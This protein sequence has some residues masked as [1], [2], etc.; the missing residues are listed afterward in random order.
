MRRPTTATVII[1]LA[2][3]IAAQ[4]PVV[5]K[6][7]QL[8]VHTYVV[9]QPASKLV[10]DDAAML[11][12]AKAARR[13]LENDL[14]SYDIRDVTTRRDAFASLST[15]A[16]LEGRYDDALRLSDTV[17]ALQT[18]PAARLISGLYLRPRIAA[19]RAGAA[20]AQKAFRDELARA[21]A[22]LPYDSVQAEL[23]SRAGSL[24]TMA[25]NVMYGIIESSFDPASQ[26][27]RISKDIA[28]SLIDAYSEIRSLYPYR[29]TAL[30]QLNAVIDAHHVEKAD[31]WAARDVSLD[32]VQGLTP[33]VV[34]I[35]DVGVDL[36]LFPGRVWSNAKEIPGN[37]R[38]DDGNG[39]ID[40]VH[41]IGFGWDGHDVVGP[42]RPLAPYSATDMHDAARSVKGFG[43]LQAHVR[44]P[45]AQAAQQK[46]AS[47]AQSEVKAFAERVSF[48][49]NYAHG[50]HVA[51]IAARGNPAV[52]L[53]VIR[54]EFPYELISPAPT[55][56]WAS[57][58]ASAMRRS[59]DYYR[60][61]GAR[62]VNMSWGVSV[63]DIEHD[64]E[65]NRAGGTEEQRKKLARMYFDTV[66]NAFRSAIAAAPGVLFVAAAG[67]SDNSNAFTE[68]MPASIDLPNVITVGAV[69]KAGDQAAFTSFGKVD[70]YAN[71]Y[72][73]ESVLPGGEK[74]KWSGTSMASPQVANL[75]AK[76]LATHPGLSAAEV[77][78]LIVAGADARQV[79][80]QTIKLLNERR[81]FDLAPRGNP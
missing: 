37:G 65:A 28:L 10:R 22:A 46:I 6:A 20:G 40:D 21:L 25:P 5:T 39:F 1:A 68:T 80:G 63:E 23:K 52:R 36:A 64:L 74:Q 29:E 2:T 73:V 43:D 66:F 15:I 49:S 76:L 30:A 70:V 50:T 33:V 14:Q 61:T 47:L 53:Q 48:Y 9:T 59:I 41:G 56:A 58:F 35:S 12:L 19:S 71:G 60:R 81:S 51:G 69:D 24:S 18:K 78:R 16:L 45:E 27:G 4:K 34:A 32:K 54:F 79:S 7:D 26:S 57:G 67:N 11:A 42:M 13:D 3:P 62:V 44:S 17:R 77:K 8:P 72:E 31:I 38:D 75:A 55:A